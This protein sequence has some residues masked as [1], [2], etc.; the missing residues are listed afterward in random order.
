MDAG[1]EPVPA[2]SEVV[3]VLTIPEG[4]EEVF[5]D[6]QVETMSCDHVRW[7]LNL[8]RLKIKLYC[9]DLSSIVLHCNTR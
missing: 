1:S 8:S 5:I 3:A 6:T 2:G 9:I 4:M 7:S